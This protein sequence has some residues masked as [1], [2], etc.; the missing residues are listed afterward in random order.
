MQVT[1]SENCTGI[2][3]SKSF[4]PV[5]AK[6]FCRNICFDEG[7]VCNRNFNN[8]AALLDENSRNSLKAEKRTNRYL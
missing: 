8:C 6:G 2:F 5:G 3:R 1:K 7:F 4:V